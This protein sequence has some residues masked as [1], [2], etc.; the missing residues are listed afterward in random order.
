MLESNFGL[1]VITVSLLSVIVLFAVSM[2]RK[3]NKRRELE[4][5][6]AC[7]NYFDA[8]K[9]FADNLQD[10]NLEKRCYELGEIY[11]SYILPDIY[12]YP[13]YDYSFYLNYID[14]TAERRKMIERDLSGQ[15]KNIDINPESTGDQFEKRVA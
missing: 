2:T 14:N 9:L 15:T 12:N 8:L 3:L 7:Q 10:S 6:R 13:I 11:Y 5:E 1:V 4:K